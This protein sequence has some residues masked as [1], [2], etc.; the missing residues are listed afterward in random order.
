V[1]V[2]RGET[3]RFDMRKQGPH[4]RFKEWAQERGL[5]F[6]IGRQNSRLGL[7]NSDWHNPFKEGV[8]GTREEIVRRFKEERMPELLSE[9][10]DPEEYEGKALG[11]WCKPDEACHGDVLIDHHHDHFTYVTTPDQLAE[12]ISKLGRATLV[13]LDLETVGTDPATG[14][15]RLAQVSDGET[16]F[17]VDPKPLLGCVA[18]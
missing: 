14:T 9:G 16:T 2:T 10:K 12:A 15:L 8:D 6:Y 3:V 11:C 5:L 13:G 17:V 4:V 1:E 7:K 18:D